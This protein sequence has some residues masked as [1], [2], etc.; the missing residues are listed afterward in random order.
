MTLRSGPGVHCGRLSSPSHRGPRSEATTCPSE[1][2]STSVSISHDPGGHRTTRASSDSHRGGPKPVVDKRRLERNA[3][4]QRRSLKISQKIDE[5]RA[6]LRQS[7]VMVKSS[8]SNILQE[9]TQLICALQRRQA[10]LEGERNHLLQL[11]QGLSGSSSA[12]A[13]Q[14]AAAA[15]AGAAAAAGGRTL[16]QQQLAAAAAAAAAA[17]SVGMDYQLIFHNAAIPLAVGSVN[18]NIVDCNARMCAFTGY[19]REELLALTVFNLVADAFLQQSFAL[20]SGMLTVAGAAAAAAQQR[21]AHVDMPC[22]LRDGQPGGV[23]S[24]AL[25]RDELLRPRFFAISLA[26]ALL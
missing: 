20:I 21:G 8:K 5:L 14:P 6:L 11:V 25:V 7:G 23:L 26:P 4:E 19:R 12:Q 2:T 18:G 3:R 13:A 22:K 10:L 16:Q 15:T 24:I 17:A 9:A 1:T